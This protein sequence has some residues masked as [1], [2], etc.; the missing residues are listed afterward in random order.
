MPNIGN[1]TQVFLSNH[2]SKCHTY[3]FQVMEMSFPK[4]GQDE[5][6]LHGKVMGH[7]AVV[8]TWDRFYVAAKKGWVPYQSLYEC[9]CI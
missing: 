9:S 2:L 6:S 1:H 8:L 5:N 3:I 7:L 4:Y